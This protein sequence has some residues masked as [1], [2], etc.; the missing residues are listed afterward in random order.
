MS[1]FSRKIKKSKSKK[2]IY[3]KEE[4]LAL[5]LPEYHSLV[6]IKILEKNRNILE[7]NYLLEF[8]T[9]FF[10]DQIKKELFGEEAWNLIY[11]YSEKIEI[12]LK[13]ILQKHSISF[14]IQVYRRIGLGIVSDLNRRADESTIYQLREMTELAIKK[15]SKL[16]SKDIQNA[17]DISDSDVLGGLFKKYY[18]ELFKDRFDDIYRY[19][20]SKNHQII[21]DFSEQDYIDI[22]I[23]E[24]YVH[25]YWW[26]T[27][28]MRSI[29]KGAS[30]YLDNKG[31]VQEKRSTELDFLITNYDKRIEDEAFTTSNIGVSFFNGTNNIQMP[32][33]QYNYKNL[34]MEDVDVFY[35]TFN[36]KF[37][38]DLIPNFYWA[39]IDTEEFIQTYK[40]LDDKLRKKYNFTVSQ[41]AIYLTMLHLNSVTNTFNVN[42]KKLKLIPHLNLYQRAY[43]FVDKIEDINK[44]ILTLYEGFKTKL[45]T[46]EI[47]FNDEVIKI[48]SDYLTL[49]SQKKQECIALWSGGPNYTFIKSNNIFLVDF[50]SS[51]NILK[52][53]FFGVRVNNEK[54]TIF[55]DNFRDYVK[56]HNLNL[57]NYRKIKNFNDEEREID[58]AIRADN[59]LFLIECRAIEKPLDFEIGKIKTLQKRK[60]E[61][62]SKL[63]QVLSLGDFITNNKT[64]RNYDFSWVNNIVPIVVTPFTEWIDSIEEKYWITKDTPRVLNPEEVIAL[65]KKYRGQATM[66]TNHLDGNLY[67]SL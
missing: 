16:N 35:K 34:T 63:S 24:R 14:W 66:T 32:C 13:E 64:G 42:E 58:L 30:I 25:E 3:T 60:E 67:K 43:L 39:M 6:F 48:I 29:G 45:N 20:L 56:E 31:I 28:V 21:T 55:E 57:L 7:K 61:L 8:H 5:Q 40:F 53:L 54:G 50:T 62:D 49:D 38:L 11:A 33:P 4:I 44:S 22:Y 19:T 36:C 10:K 27:A 59:T 26:S 12:Q 41:I 46:Q 9:L 15:F 37:Q 18:S 1:N 17:K 65:I 47:I 51:A 23:V 52:N 2:E